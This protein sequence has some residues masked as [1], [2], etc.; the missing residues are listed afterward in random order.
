MFKAV[1]VSV[2]AVK[3]QPSMQDENVN[4]DV[5]WRAYVKELIGR[6]FFCKCIYFFNI[7]KYVLLLEYGS[8]FKQDLFFCFDLKLSLCNL[9]K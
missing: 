5:L 1:F 7:K 3:K 6:G 9:L 2:S 4:V 8:E